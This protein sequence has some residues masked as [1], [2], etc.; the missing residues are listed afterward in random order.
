MMI[1]VQWIYEM[2]DLRHL[3]FS[4]S[5]ETLFWTDFISETETELGT[6][7]RHSSIIKFDQSS[8]VEEDALGCFGSQI[9]F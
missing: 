5:Q 7:K 1:F 4:H 8:E 6:S 2:F 9:A 3:K